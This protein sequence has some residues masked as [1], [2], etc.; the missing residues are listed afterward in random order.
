MAG[1]AT[2]VNRL[3]VAVGA[4]FAIALCAASGPAFSQPSTT[5]GAA[6]PD[7]R[8]PA[9]IV[10]ESARSR[11]GTGERYD[12]SYFSIPYP[13][14]DVPANRGVC[15]DVV[16]RAWRAIGLDLQALVHEDM[17][18]HFDAYP[19]LWGL[20][21]TDRNI[22]HRRVPNLQTFF[23]RNGAEIAERSQAD[24][25]LPGDLVTWMLPRNLPHIG[26]VS[27]RRSADG[28]RPLILHNIGAGSA[29]EDILFA[30]PIT[31][32]YRFPPDPAHR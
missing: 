24:D 27:D 17:T 7:L 5:T 14:G 18:R 30:Y 13:N 32:H 16:I 31:G 15:T 11:I 26:I 1:K 3:L 25:F 4:S 8:E 21:R 19:K 22:D 12:P 20:K 10:I 23:R 6:P 9:R 29:E 28:K 2:V